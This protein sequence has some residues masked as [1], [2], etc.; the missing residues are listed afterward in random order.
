MNPSKQH[1]FAVVT[2]DLEERIAAKWPEPILYLDLKAMTASALRRRFALVTDQVAFLSDNPG[3]AANCCTKGRDIFDA[4][5]I[6][7]APIR[8]R[9][10]V[11]QF[12]ADFHASF[13]AFCTKVLRHLGKLQGLCGAAGAEL[14]ESFLAVVSA[15]ELRR[16]DLA[17]VIAAAQ[18]ALTESFMSDERGEITKWH[19]AL[20]M[21]ME[22][23]LMDEVEF[24]PYHGGDRPVAH[25]L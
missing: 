24:C 25:A 1:I 15:S 2:H 17:D 22:L 12:A 6:D 16:S 5:S 23:G 20:D 10:F 14:K 21:A 7:Y 3:I 8:D 13:D 4:L 9:L 18:V 11:Q 19:G